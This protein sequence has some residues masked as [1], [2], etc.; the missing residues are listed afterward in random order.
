MGEPLETS[1]SFVV[2]PPYGNA[3]ALRHIKRN[4][5]KYIFLLILDPPG[6]PSQ[7]EV[8]DSGCS[9]I[10][11]NWKKPVNDGGNPVTGYMVE[12]KHVDDTE[13]IPCNSFPTKTTEY[14]ATNLVEGQTYEL[15]VKA[16]NEAGPGAPSKPC[17]PQKA[18]PP[19]CKLHNLSSEPFLKL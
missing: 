7:P 18:E 5:L 2:K 11:I 3:I 4:V 16:V 13:W 10:K 15:R 19:I 12:M 1:H 9:F 6:C 14:T 17:K 8:I